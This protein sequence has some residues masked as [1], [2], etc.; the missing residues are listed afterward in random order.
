MPWLFS[1]PPNTT[2]VKLWEVRIVGEVLRSGRYVPLALLPW[3]TPQLAWKSA[4]PALA[5]PE[6]VTPVR[7]IVRGVA[8]GYGATL[9]VPPSL[10]ASSRPGRRGRAGRAQEGA[11][12]A[13]PP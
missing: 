1:A 11:S 13:A 3:Q 2:E 9:A 8:L 10:K 5:S 4:L 7:S 6:E 12:A